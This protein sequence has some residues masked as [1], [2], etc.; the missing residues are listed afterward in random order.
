MTTQT[1]TTAFVPTTIVSGLTFPVYA[2]AKAGRAV[3]AARLFGKS[4]HLC[5]VSYEE[6]KALVLGRQYNHTVV[7]RMVEGTGPQ[8]PRIKGGFVSYE[9]SM[10][11]NVEYDHAKYPKYHPGLYDFLFEYKKEN[12]ILYANSRLVL[13]MA[14][15]MGIHTREMSVN[16]A[17]TKGVMTYVVCSKAGRS[18]VTFALNSLYSGCPVRMVLY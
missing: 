4:S 10:A 17:R 13:G 15:S 16:D 3:D 8:T 2:F 12:R 7:Q 14:R 5:Q 11:G 18:R 1:T 9:V 6:V